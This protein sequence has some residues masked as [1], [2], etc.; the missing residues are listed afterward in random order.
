VK[1]PMTKTT[2]LLSS[3]SGVGYEEPFQ[4]GGVSGYNKESMIV[5]NSESRV[6]R[7]PRFLH[8]KEPCYRFR[9][10]VGA[11]KEA[12]T[13]VSSLPNSPYFVSGNK[14]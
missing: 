10:R 7:V 5:D 8:P 3:S 12:I 2:Q 9:K 1:V 4:W 11:L 13:K 6:W 14:K